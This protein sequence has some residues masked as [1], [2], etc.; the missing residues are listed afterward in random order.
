MLLHIFNVSYCGVYCS[1]VD[2]KILKYYTTCKYYTVSLPLIYLYAL[3][4]E[5]HT[6][7]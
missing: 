2:N 4:V 3:L 5:N 6:D 7:D 1:F